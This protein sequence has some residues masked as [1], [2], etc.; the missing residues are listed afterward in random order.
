MERVTLYTRTKKES[1][2]VKLR[3]R[4]REGKVDLFYSSDIVADIRTLGKFNEDGTLRPRVQIYDKDLHEKIL[5]CIGAGKQ[6]YSDMRENGISPTSTKWTE[7]I[8]NI[9]RPQQTHAATLT[10]EFS[11]FIDRMERDGIIGWRRVDYYEVLLRELERYLIIK[12]E[13]NMTVE[14]FDT[15]AIRDFRD[16]LQTEHQYVEKWI[17]LYKNLKRTNVPHQPRRQNTVAAKMKALKCFFSDIVD[18]G[19]LSKSPFDSLG[20]GKT[21]ILR[22]R[23]DAPV[24]L[25]KEEYETVKNCEVPD[26]LRETKDA[27]LLQCALGCRI[28]DFKVMGMKNVGV[29]NG[30]AFVH[31]LPQKTKNSQIDNKE[32][33]TPIIRSALEIVKRYNFSFE[34]LKNVS[35]CV[36]YNARIVELLKLAGIDRQCAV[37]DEEKGVNDYVPLWQLGCSKLARKTHVDRMA[38]VQIDIYKSG[39]HKQ[40]SKAA[41]RYVEDLTLREKLDLMNLAFS[42]EDYRVD[43]DLNIMDNEKQDDLN[44]MVENLS[45]ADKKK[46]LELLLK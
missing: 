27:F 25:N 34:I 40:G 9:L 23:Y 1:G 8:E 33:V 20:K 3:F 41:Q 18:S 31:Y 29:G 15:Q 11:D 13:S 16:F 42:E 28:S 38:K 7:G 17:D 35:G 30:I 37:Y 22:C 36:G 2:N 21:A 39:L 6:A 4:L 44:I 10:E 43:D 12:G 24:C 46:L 5:R 45:N 14:R 19:K 26:R 32:I